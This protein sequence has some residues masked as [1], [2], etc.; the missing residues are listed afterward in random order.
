[1][2]GTDS[3]G[4]LFR[5]EIDALDATRVTVGRQAR[6]PGAVLLELR[7]CPMGSVLKI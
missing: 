3:S 7:R 1:M 4:H 6:W 2:P 5:H